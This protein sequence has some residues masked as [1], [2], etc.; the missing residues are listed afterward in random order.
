M[1][2]VLAETPRY[3]WPVTVRVPS[4]DTAGEV[5]AQGFE[6]LFEPQGQDEGAEAF[7]AIGRAG[8]VR[9]SAARERDI[10][11]AICKDWRGV[12]DEAGGEVPFSAE[13]LD[14]AS[15]MAWFRRG[16]FAAYRASLSGEAARLGN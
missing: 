8:S 7:E 10:L 12:V 14:Q 15:Q 9:E 5:V 11:Q 2:F 16:I 3:W 1:K 4:R 6:V 13:F